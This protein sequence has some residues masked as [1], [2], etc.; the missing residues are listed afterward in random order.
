MSQT[1]EKSHVAK[2]PSPTTA[3]EGV[4]FRKAGEQG[5][6]GARENTSFFPASVQAK[7]EVSHPDDP[8]EKEADAVADSVMRMPSPEA[9]GGGEVPERRE[10]EGPSVRRSPLAGARI[11]RQAGWGGFA[12]DLDPGDGAGSSTMVQTK[13]QGGGIPADLARSARGPPAEAATPSTTRSFESTLASTKGSGSPLPSDVRQSMESRFGADFGGVRVHTGSGAEGLSAEIGAQ[14]FT[15]G[16]DIYF[17]AGKYDPG[18]TSG[19]HLL[20]H[21][22]THTIQQGASQPRADAKAQGSPAPRPAGAIQRRNLS[23]SLQ[24]TE[25]GSQ[26]QAA[27]ELATAEAGKV[28]SKEPGPDGKRTG[29]ERLLEYFKTTFGEDRILPEGAAFQQDTVNESQIKTISSFQG[30]VMGGDG[31]TVLHDQMRDAMPSWCGIFAF[32]ALNKGGIPLR[33][34]RLGQSI[35]PPDAAL[36]GGHLPQPGD[37]AWRREFSHYALVASADAT[38][39]TT[40]NGNTAGDDNVGGQVQVL[41]H[42]RSHWYA[43]FDPTRLMDGS[44]RDPASPENAGAAPVRSLRELRKSLFNVDRKSQP[45]TASKPPAE[46]TEEKLQAKP[47]ETREPEAVAASSGGSGSGGSGDG[48]P[49]DRDDAGSGAP[50]AVQAS[51]QRSAQPDKERETDPEAPASV[52]ESVQRRASA[53]EK[54]AETASTEDAPVQRAPQDTRSRG[55]PVSPSQVLS[56]VGRRIQRWSL[57][58]AWDAVSGA[59][60]EAAAW[61]ERGLDAAREWMFDQVRDFVAN[62]RGYRLLCLILGADPITGVPAPLTGESLLEAGLEILPGGSMFRSLFVRLGIY[63]D[64]ATWLQGRIEDLSSLA[65]GIGARFASFWDSLSLDDIAD[66]S[67]VLDRVGELLRGTIEDIVGFVERSASTLLEM[68]KTVM[69]REIAAFVRARLPNL[70]PLLTVALGFDP[71]TMQDVPRNGTNILHALLETSE[72]G[73]E[74]RKQMLE[75]GTFQ[76]IAGWIDRGIAVFSTAWTM[77]RA[78]I[79]G[80][81]DFVTIENL[82]SPLDTFGRIWETFAAPVRIVTDFV[83][84]A[85]LE[86]LRVVKDAILGRLSAFARETRGYPLLCVIIG[87]DPFTGVAVPRTVHNVVRGFM[88]LMEGGEEQYNQLRESG[89]IDRIVAKVEA[90]VDRLGMTPAAIIQLFIDLWNSFSIR[91]L[92]RPLECF[93]RIVAT[94]GT[95]IARLVRFVIEIVIIAIEAILILMN[96][97]FAIVANILAKA[98]E[99]WELIKSDP[100]GFF[101]NILRAIKQGFLQFFDNIGTHLLNGVVGWLMAELRDA[102]VPILTDFSL[103]G[104]I[105]WVLEVLGIS[106]EKIWEKLA[107]HPRIGPERVARIRGMI[108]TLEGIWTFIQDVQ[109]RGMAAIWDKIQEQLSNLWNTVLDAVKNWIMERIVNAVTTRLLSMLDPTGVMAVVNSVL[110]MYRAVQ[111]FIR[112]ITEML[113]VVNSFV[114][115]VLEIAQGNIQS[116]ADYL[117]NAMDRAM[118]V[119]IGFLANQVGLSGVGRRVAEMI[120]RVRGMVDEALTWLVNRAV[121]TGMAL[122]DRAMA[123]GRS[124]A[125]AVGGWLARL[126]GLEK[127]FQG[128]DGGNHRL[129]FRSG[130]G[131]ATLMINPDPAGPFEAWISGIDIPAGAPA[132]NE[133]LRHK[134]RAIEYAREVE[135]IKVRPAPDTAAEEQKARDLGAKLDQLSAETGPLFAGQK[136]PCSKDQPT[137]LTFNPRH[138]GKYG[139]QMRANTLTNI[140]MPE[141]SVPSVTLH[142]SFNIINQR[143]NRGGSYYVLGHLLNHN[144]GGTGRD[145]ANLTPLT[146]EANSEHERVVESRVKNAV[147]AGNVVEYVV[148]AEYGRSVGSSPDPTIREIKQHEVDVP[149]GLVCEATL[150]APAAVAGGTESR[151]PLVPAGTRIPNEVGLNDADYDLVGIRHEPVYLDS[152]NSSAI[153]AIEGVSTTF[154]AKIVAAYEDKQTNDGTRF[155]SF[156]ALAS[157]R[158]SDGRT[159]T[160]NQSDII[161]GFTGDQFTHVHLFRN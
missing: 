142:Q 35:I 87:R 143:R 158:F 21:E 102:G 157:Y 79:A 100:A 10:E 13:T 5:F 145:W 34:W 50:G 156:N 64:V 113:Q 95:P 132:R 69:V 84:E 104:V 103:R 151:T 107:A 152:G 93:R 3:S 46:E 129:Y 26:R 2:P 154:A 117:E 33:K 60:S 121:D 114:E 65:S 23:R 44:L 58:G 140:R 55:P 32:W 106:M 53:E 112:Y 68:I 22:L 116:A 126:L 89:A 134:Q 92:A 12:S 138:N 14:A 30:D 125:G 130:G 51:L 88:S 24:R 81:W 31:L 153:A 47:E 97:P 155:A 49:E 83:I 63:G 20:A 1:A 17:N 7:L 38:T 111:S 161:R 144:L 141:G 57:S 120:E 108:N 66:P 150:I 137:G 78:A 99:A 149:T 105:G 73:R 48:A 127:R 159:F 56:K 91:D 77:L 128:A 160:S 11:H 109:E 43:F 148:R 59:L 80:V 75:T 15:H 54:E 25:A 52:T 90:A 122:L 82:F 110:A 71:E 28:S 4:F 27:V 72:D 86:I 41:T 8:Q 135:T 19:G 123:M 62:I 37:I 131:G 40:V 16:N 124:A 42:P 6:F 101:K 147:D 9:E 133:K 67:G 18:S 61:V 136:P 94:F 70:Y 45:E 85:G 74:Q 139:S 118:P 119:V 76:R 115:G 29:W 98:R 96:F 146:R 36:P 39:V